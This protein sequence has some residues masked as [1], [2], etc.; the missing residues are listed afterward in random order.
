M[1]YEMMIPPFER[2]DFIEM[3]KKQAQEYFEW[4]MN[5]IEDRITMLLTKI[6]MDGVNAEFDFSEE[7]LIPLWEWYE[8][9]I[10]LRMLDNSEYQD[11][12]NKY[13]EWMKQYISEKDL[14]FETIMFGIDVSLY[15]AEVIIRNNG[16]KIKWGYFTKPKN[17]SSVNEPT[18]LGFKYDKDL[19]PRLIV[20]NCTRKSSEE[21]RSTRL[22]DV[23]KVW[24]TFV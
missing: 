6:K 2:V 14:S 22:F 19:N 4:Y 8:K 20:E 1:I 11:R 5:Q 16:D 3:N 7:S 24:M 23:Y 15:F 17:R 18:L 12:V 10:S 9:K 21:K 13:P